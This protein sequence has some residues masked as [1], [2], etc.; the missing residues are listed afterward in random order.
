[1]KIVL[2]FIVSMMIYTPLEGMQKTKLQ[3][4]VKMQC[5][6][7]AEGDVIMA[8][9]PERR[10]KLMRSL[11]DPEY[12]KEYRAQV[13][14][15]LESLSGGDPDWPARRKVIREAVEHGVH[16]DAIRYF[17][18]D[19]PLFEAVL[20]K[21]EEFVRYLLINLAC[22]HQLYR[23]ESLLF[24]SFSANT[25]AVKN[26]FE[27]LLKHGAL[28]NVRDGGGDTLLYRISGRS[29]LD[30]SYIE[31]CK[32][33]GV[34]PLAANEDGNSSLQGVLY[35]LRLFP[36]DEAFLFATKKAQALIVLGVSL[37]YV[38]P[39]DGCTFVQGLHIEIKRVREESTFNESKQKKIVF[40]NQLLEDVKKAAIAR[41]QLIRDGIGD[42]ISHGPKELVLEYYEAEN[43]KQT[44]DEINTLHEKLKE[45][46]NGTRRAEER[47][48]FDL[49][50]F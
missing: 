28:V 15:K 46:W 32:A 13:V 29:N 17:K 50:Q 11:R 42:A 18:T 2:K 10:E 35:S 20:H 49:G 5:A 19:F 31:I 48:M 37:D 40:F 30:A 44:E 6:V 21:D 41:N 12:L 36:S 7:D 47:Y 9:E 14:T 43:F 22:V 24:S 45:K 34:E 39:Y 3:H 16:P 8:I 33:Y 23:G 38:Q 26:I 4:E 25:S 27:L 1:M